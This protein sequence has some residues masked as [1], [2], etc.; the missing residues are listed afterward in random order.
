MRE[1]DM[2]SYFQIVTFNWFGD[3]VC[4]QRVSSRWIRVDD[5]LL[6]PLEVVMDS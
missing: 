3:V 2:M 6:A 1:E 4:L 5:Q